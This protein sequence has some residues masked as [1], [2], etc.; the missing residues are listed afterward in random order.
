MAHPAAAHQAAPSQTVAPQARGLPY[1]AVAS[2]LAVVHYLNLKL[3]LGLDYLVVLVVL[4]GL[5]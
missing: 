1:Q 4:E 2:H 5:V 3:H